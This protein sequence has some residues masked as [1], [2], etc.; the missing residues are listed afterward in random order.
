MIDKTIYCF[1]VGNNNTEMNQNRKNGIDSLVKNSKANV[2]VVDNSN[3]NRFILS[4]YP[5]HD[6]FTYLSDVHKS[7][8]LRC[9]F[10]HHYGG[11]ILRYKTM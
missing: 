4:D 10:M 9:Y 2:V 7:D 11:R 8:Y 3:L 1:W 6:G 5:L